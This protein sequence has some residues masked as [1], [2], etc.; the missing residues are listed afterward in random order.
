MN[1]LL[2]TFH[3]CLPVLHFTLSLFFSSE[4]IFLICKT[5]FIYSRKYLLHAFLN[6]LKIP[7]QSARHLGVV[8]GALVRKNEKEMFTQ[9]SPALSKAGIFSNCHAPVAWSQSLILLTI[10]FCLR[11]QFEYWSILLRS[12]LAQ[13]MWRNWKSGA[14]GVTLVVWPFLKYDSIAQNVSHNWSRHDTSKNS[15]LITWRLTAICKV[16]DT[17]NDNPFCF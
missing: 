7:K 15:P 14:R 13:K 4:I 3:F 8:K 9:F 17:F 11:F 1:A 16:S 6:P 10:K 12:M 5:G 2:L